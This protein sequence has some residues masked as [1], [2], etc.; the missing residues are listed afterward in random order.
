MTISPPRLSPEELLDRCTAAVVE[1]GERLGITAQ[2]L[3]A[4]RTPVS[5]GLQV[6]VPWV[7]GWTAHDLV[8]HVGAV[9]RRATVA[10]RAGARRDPGPVSRFRPP[11]DDLH[12]WYAVGLTELVTALRT[13]DPDAP[14]WPVGPAAAGRVREWARRLTHEVTVHRMDLAVAAGLDPRP[15]DPVLAGDGVD[16]LL[17]VLL[18]RWAGAPPL[19]TARVTVGVTATDLERAWTVRVAD[20]EVTVTDEPAAG[21]DARLEGT[22]D[23]L[24]RRLWGR[25][26]EVRTT[27]DPRAAALLRGR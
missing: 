14:A 18:P 26:A 10:V 1:E 11:R 5:G 4:G 17:A 27:G 19:A 3:A 12:G 16:E 25:P 9:M 22:A 21:C 15:A 23:Q 24:L 7:P 8:A 6:E 2:E 13:T 20:A